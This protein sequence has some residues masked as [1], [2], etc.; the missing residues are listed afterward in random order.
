MQENFQKNSY[1]LLHLAEI[2]GQDAV[3]AV[4]KLEEDNELKPAMFRGA[5]NL[6][7]PDVRTMFSWVLFFGGIIKRIQTS[8][9]MAAT[10]TNPKQVQAR[11]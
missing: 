3:S 2:A 7:P 6:V 1:G 9:L 8:L 10:N 5:E 4:A 11:P